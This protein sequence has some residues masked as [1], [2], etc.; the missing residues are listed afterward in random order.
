MN[1][2]VVR[3]TLFNFELNAVNQKK[4]GIYNIYIYLIC[5]IFKQYYMQFLTD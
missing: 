1:H 3:N 4:L 5:K 2:V